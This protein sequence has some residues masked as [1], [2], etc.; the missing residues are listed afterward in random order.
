MQAKED[1]P[2]LLKR[3]ISCYV[4]LKKLCADKCF[5]PDTEPHWSISFIQQ[6]EKGEEFCFP[7]SGLLTLLAAKLSYGM[8]IS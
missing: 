3:E 8:L 6:A 2:L 5:K 4:G 7:S 1:Y